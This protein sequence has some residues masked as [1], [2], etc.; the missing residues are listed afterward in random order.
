MLHPKY[1]SRRVRDMF[2]EYGCNIRTLL[3]VLSG[4]KEEVLNKIN[5]KT[6]NLSLP[7]LQNMLAGPSEVT[8]HASHYII[9]TSCPEQP[10]PKEDKYLYSDDMVCTISSHV[11]W[12]SLFDRFG[13]LL[14]TEQSLLFRLF[15][16]IPETAVTAGWLWEP[17]GHARFCKGGHFDLIQMQVKGKSLVQTQETRS[18][19]VDNMIPTVLETNSVCSPGKYYIPPKKNQA[20][21]DA[22]F[23]LNEEQIALQFTISITHSLSGAGFPVLNGVRPESCKE[24]AVIFVVPKAR[25]EKFRSQAPSSDS[26]KKFK[27]YVLP[28]DDEISKYCP[29]SADI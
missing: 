25:A 4:N 24:Q 28:L 21:F 23:L 17:R 13:V 1:D 11:V 18:I 10:K 12:K 27:Y 26:Q 15:K 14:Y 9:Q 3:D 19:I 16:P 2:R 7:V 22:C 20:T 5:Q 6:A 29:S 8:D